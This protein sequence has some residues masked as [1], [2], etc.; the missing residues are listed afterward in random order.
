MQ[1]YILYIKKNL[2]N[3]SEAG[4]GNKLLVV[5]CKIIPESTTIRY[6]KMCVIN[7]NLKMFGYTFCTHRY[8]CWSLM[9]SAEN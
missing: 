7:A 4:K 6:I 5:F 9:T 1:I 8:I 2:K 3:L